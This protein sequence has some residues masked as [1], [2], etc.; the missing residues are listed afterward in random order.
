M[1][2]NQHS[3]ELDCSEFSDKLGA[4][5]PECTVTEVESIT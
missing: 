5:L 1:E 3:S 4:L 2:I